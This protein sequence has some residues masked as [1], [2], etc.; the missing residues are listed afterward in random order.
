[1]SLDEPPVNV[2]FDLDGTLTDPELGITG[3]I[4]YALGKLGAPIP[5]R[6]DLRRYIGPP[7]RSGFVSLLGTSEEAVIERAVAL[8]RERFADVGLYENELYAHTPDTLQRLVGA[9]HRLFVATSKPEVYASRIVQHFGVDKYFVH[10]YGSE[11]S[12]ER[13]DKAELLAHILA[14][15]QINPACAIMVGDR[16]HDVAGARAN[17]V[18][19][20]AVLWGYG[21]EEELRQ[22]D[23]IVDAW[24]AVFDR[25]QSLSIPSPESGRS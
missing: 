10:V 16:H 18:A 23:H 1:L 4:A 5:A 22:A 7:L 15:E 17:G 13:S 3:C 20:I 19:S 21:T 12:G 25:V 2:L 6:A 14:A 24:P 11:L 9:G 8:Y